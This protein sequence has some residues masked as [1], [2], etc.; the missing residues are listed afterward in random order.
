MEIFKFNLLKFNIIGMV[1][2]HYK[3]SL[4]SK[5]KIKNILS[6]HYRFMVFKSVKSEKIKIVLKL[7]TPKVI[8][9]YFNIFC[10]SRSIINI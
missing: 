10:H 9:I 7:K 5:K 1:W 8:Y 6:R 2:L 4:K 3:K